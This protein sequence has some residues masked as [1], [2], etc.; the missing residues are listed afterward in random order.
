MRNNT[1]KTDKETML[2]VIEKFKNNLL[3]GKPIAE[4]I[5]YYSKSSKD[6]LDYSFNNFNYRI[7]PE[8]ILLPERE[9]PKPLTEDE[10]DF[11]RS[12]NG[13]VYKPSI[14]GYWYN[15]YFA[16]D[17]SLTNFPI[18]YGTE[19]EAIKAAKFMSGLGDKHAYK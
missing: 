2:R 6:W 14:G 13:Y 7:K 15:K 18:L 1:M 19:E 10:I 9:I 5:Q 11:I 16:D 3:N 8:N 12:R 17:V 4:D